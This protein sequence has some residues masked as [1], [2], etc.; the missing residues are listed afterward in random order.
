MNSLKSLALGTALVLGVAAGDSASV[1]AQTAE[2]DALK[3]AQRRA[4][5]DISLSPSGNKIAYIAPN[6]DRG[7]ALFIVDLTVGGSPKGILGNSEANTDIDYCDWATE[8][9]LVCSTSVIND[10]S[11]L[12]VGY[13]RL[14]S[15]SAVTGK[16]QMLTQRT[17]SRALRTA[18]DGGSVVALDIRGEDNQILMTRQWVPENNANSRLGNSREGLGVDRIDVVTGKRDAEIM[19]DE[20]ASWYV[21]DQFGEVRLKARTPTDGGTGQLKGQ[22]IYYYRAKGERE[23]TRLSEAVLDSQ[24]SGGFRPVAVDSEQNIAYGYGSKD[25]FGAIYKVSLDGPAQPELV[26]AEPGA[27]ID[28]LIRIGRQRRVIGVSYATEKRYAEYFDPALEAL[29][30]SLSKAL[31]GTP[32]ISIVDA[33]A[34]E[35]KLMLIASSDKDPGMVYLMNR[36]TNQLEP[37]LPVRNYLDAA[38]MAE[39]KPVSFPAADGTMIPG[40]L[41]LPKGSDGTGLKA[42]V[43]PHGGPS[44]RDFWGFDWLVQYFAARGYAV[45]QPNYRG[46]SGYGSEWFGRNGFQAWD[47]AIGDVND[48]GRWLISEG[49]ADP[50]KLSIVGWSYGGYAAL[51]SQVADA[52][53][54]K[55]VVAIA[56][57][58]DLQKL[59]THALN[60]NNSSLVRDFVGSGPHVREGSPAQNVEAFAAPVLMYHGTMDQNVEV[61]QSRYM[62]RRLEGAGK[63]VTYVEFDGLDHQLDET[64]ARYKMLTEIDAFLTQHTGG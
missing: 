51:Q 12:L 27:D 1:Y 14:L 10:E 15:V 30:V 44:A 47:V 56:P 61:E 45:L 22:R 25:G 6:G 33:S 4:I 43:L 58:T 9:Y 39:M 34:D 31:P 35:S 18:Q 20:D 32:A 52:D 7:E 64:K 46:S 50:D 60:Y 11:G 28:S 63:D 2:Q 59:L 49:I 40:Y 57:V 17:S 23:W 21:A 38:D 5:L 19:P 62:A 24:S 13:D 55:A 26:A 36:T 37:L 48:A 29:A 54:Y 3:F 53:L 42:I 16:V 41:T 8:E